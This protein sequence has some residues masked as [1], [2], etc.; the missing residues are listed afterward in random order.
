MIIIYDRQAQTVRFVS[1][2]FEYVQTGLPKDVD[3]AIWV[4][5]YE[6]GMAVELKILDV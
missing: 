2:T 4:C 1:K 6:M 5:L 3:F